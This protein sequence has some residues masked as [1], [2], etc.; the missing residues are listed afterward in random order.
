MEIRSLKN[1]AKEASD[2]Q[3]HFQ[4]KEIEAQ[5]AV[6]ERDGTIAR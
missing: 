4:N 5:G 2:S 1:A 3:K 6:V